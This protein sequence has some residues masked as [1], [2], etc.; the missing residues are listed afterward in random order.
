MFKTVLIMNM[1]A[2]LLIAAIFLITLIFGKR[3]GAKTRFFLWFLPVIRLICPTLPQSSFGIF[4]PAEN[5]ITAQSFIAAPSPLPTAQSAAP[6]S[7]PT[8]AGLTAYDVCGAIWMIGIIVL[9]GW[10][11]ASNLAFSKKIKYAVKGKDA[12]YSEVISTPMV[13]GVLR[14]K[15]LLPLYLNLSEQQKD[16]IIAHEKA[17]IKRNDLILFAL[18]HILCSLFWFNPFVWFL[19]YQIKQETELLCDAAVLKRLNRKD[20]L[21]Y[22]ET[23]LSFAAKFRKT[24]YMRMAAG[25]LGG[26]RQLKTRI[27]MIANDSKKAYGCTL[28]G[29]LA[30]LLAGCVALTNTPQKP[31]TIEPSSQHQ[32]EPK[33]QYTYIVNGQE[34]DETLM[35]SHEKEAF[36]LL[37]LLQF[38][39]ISYEVT[40]DRSLV[41]SYQGKEVLLRE[42]RAGIY[43]IYDQGKKMDFGIV[44]YGKNGTIYVNESEA[45]HCFKSIDLIQIKEEGANPRV[46]IT[47][48][49]ELK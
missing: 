38:F 29:M 35:T 10:M 28:I 8:T 19:T 21:L 32:Q 41:L 31:K 45:I 46:E 13:F 40:S 34:I 37:K 39:N 6:S 49:Q 14:P 15:I 24:P 42:A 47:I 12:Y 20:A 9:F 23:I 2:S 48:P 17:H 26:K 16:L 25:A 7:V 43:D 30:M 22:G 11:I 3:L 1:Q 27:K 44:P 18:L 33:L 36:D 5:S 4:H